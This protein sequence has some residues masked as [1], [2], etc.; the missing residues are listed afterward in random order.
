LAAAAGGRGH[1]YVV[2]DNHHTNNVIFAALDI[3]GV[4]PVP[5]AVWDRIREVR[6]LLLR[7]IEDLSPR[8]WTF[9]FTNVLTDDK[10]SER[11]TVDRLVQVAHRTD[12]TYLPVLL[13]CEVDTL[14]AR[15]DS[16]QR[17][18]RSKWIDPP[19]VGDYVRTHHLV[20]VSDL[21]PL[22]IDTGTIAPADAAL[23]IL[24]RLDD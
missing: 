14:T 16:Q 12:R 21:H 18:D 3:D 9:V 4:K 10:A 13:Q 19:A 11:A 17:R 1:H 15:V 24:Q 2:L 23:L 7:T 22:T 5:Q 20:D 6:E 8:D